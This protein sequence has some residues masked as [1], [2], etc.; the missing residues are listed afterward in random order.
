[1]K[2]ASEFL[3]QFTERRQASQ[4][5]LGPDRRGSHG[6][7]VVHHDV[8]CSACRFSSPLRCAPELV[9]CAE[10]DRSK[11]AELLR[12]CDLFDAK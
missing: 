5:F 9:L 8:R 10:L 12:H 11:N 2:H 3:P 6:V 4:P 7:D 1:M